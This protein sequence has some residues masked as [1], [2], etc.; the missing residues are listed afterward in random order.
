MGQRAQHQEINLPPAGE[1][2]DLPAAACS[3]AAHLAGVLLDCPAAGRP[4]GVRLSAVAPV[5]ELPDLRDQLSE[6]AQEC[7]WQIEQQVA[8]E[9]QTELEQIA[10]N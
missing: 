1:L 9:I 7:G 4:A 2:L 6:E 5:G 8:E 10:R 3:A